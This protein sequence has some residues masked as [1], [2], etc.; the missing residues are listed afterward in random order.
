[1]KRLFNRATKI[2]L[3]TDSIVLVSVAMLGPFYTIF[4][5]NIGGSLFDAGL[6]I[7]IFAFVAGITTLISGKYTDRIKEKELIVVFGYA[8]MG[9]GFFLYIFVDSIW[10]LF[11]VQVLIGFA[12]AIYVPAF[13]A[14]YSKHIETCKAGRVWGAWE[15][16]NYFSV[17]VGAIIGSLIVYLW[18]FEIL[19]ILMAVFCFSSALYIYFLPRRVL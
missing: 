9:I 14:L 18:G 2:L 16:M 19:F 7:A 10:T 8:L 6:T 17:S 12:G 5:E 11:A 3:S 15:A 4:V 1:M 13:D